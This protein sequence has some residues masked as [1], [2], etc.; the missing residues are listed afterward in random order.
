MTL[1]SP[2]FLLGALAVGLPLWLHLLQRENPVRL[3]FASLMFFEKRTQSTLLQ[4]QFRYLLLLAARLALLLLLVLAFAKPVWERPPT[5]ILSGIPSLH[6]ITLDTSLSMRFG[7]RWQRAVEEARSI[8]NGLDPQDQAQILTTGPSVSVVTNPTRDK[9]E[10]L[11][12]IE[13]VEPTSSRN[14]YGDVVEAVRSLIPNPDTPVE[15]HLISDFQNAA[16]PGRFSDVALP[17][18]AQLDV[19]NVGGDNDQNW[20]IESVKGSLRLI[21]EEK[22]RLEVTVAGFS[23]D[24]ARKTVTLEINGQTIGSQSQ[25]VPAMGRASFQFDG[26]VAPEGFSRARLTL[27]PADDLPD[28]DVRLVA[29]DNSDPDPILFVTNDRRRR[30]ALYYESALNA[31]RA[32]VFHVKTSSPGEAERLNPNDY[33]LV[34]LSDVAQISAGYESKLEEYVKAGGAALITVGPETAARG[35]VALTKQR[36]AP[37]PMGSGQADFQLVGR[38]DPTHPALSQV[39]GFRG[40]K[41][42][43]YA[44]IAPAEGDEVAAQT[45]DG[46]PLIV[47]RDL[48]AGRV[49]VFGSTFDNIWNDLPIRP[50]FV[51]FTAET[52]RY[53][54]GAADEMTLAVVDSNL[55]LAR[56]REGAGMVQVFDP[57]G[58]RVLS[59]SEAVTRNDVPLEQV[60]FYE[61]RSPEGTELVAVN[62]DP[63]ESNL[64]PVERDTLELWQSTGRGGG[65]TAGGETQQAAIK[66]PPLRIW[67]VL[68]LLLAAIVLLESVIGNRR[69]DVRR[70]V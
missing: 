18:V 33:A 54:S 2:W 26:F 43:R 16:M 35:T 41:F 27:T 1:L 40:V 52:A 64:R 57:A 15:V 42:F 46:S 5:T 13:G 66:P 51:P 7:D 44:R 55:E 60:G 39:E 49:L 24:A 17:T 50:V 3:P 12:A 56:R 20:A 59:L 8:V 48:G 14:S 63:R 38:I 69:L 9:A 37:S 62:P 45:S 32:A 19:R 11:A 47:E 65:E 34:V 68:L 36:V 6:L 25:E 28:D 21:G 29:L 23:G 53:L 30:D 4:R 58:D 70:E 67:R 31:S 10:L 61:L 22:P